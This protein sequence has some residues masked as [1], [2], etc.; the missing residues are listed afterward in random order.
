MSTMRVPT[1]QVVQSALFTLFDRVGLVV[2]PL[3]PK[4]EKDAQ[5]IPIEPFEMAMTVPTA[6]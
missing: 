5:E 1:H 2:P 3:A 6:H 4:V